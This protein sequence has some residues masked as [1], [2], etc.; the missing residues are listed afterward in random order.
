M[1]LAD[2]VE[3]SIDHLPD[4]ETTE[5]AEYITV[6]GRT[7]SYSDFT[8]VETSWKDI[9]VHRG[10]GIVTYSDFYYNNNEYSITISTG[11]SLKDTSFALGSRVPVILSLIASTRLSASTLTEGTALEVTVRITDQD[12]GSVSD[13][14]VTATFNDVSFVLS[15]QGS[16]GYEASLSTEG[17]EAG[18]YSV[19][20]EAYKTGFQGVTDSSSVVVQSAPIQSGSPTGQPGIPGFPM[21][22]ILMGAGLATL[23]AAY[24]NGR[25]Q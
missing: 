4:R 15:P 10:T 20:V 19:T 18:T 11:I 14:E 12:G 1:P 9:T 3:G 24:V 22:S 2:L 17:L 23:T 21:L 7:H 25:R 13:A 5:S 8:P 16:G 6:H